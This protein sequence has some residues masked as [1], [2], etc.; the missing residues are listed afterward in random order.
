[1]L[2]NYK[3]H[4]TRVDSTV[5]SRGFKYVNET[6]NCRGTEVEDYFVLNLNPFSLAER[7]KWLLNYTASYGGRQYCCC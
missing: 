1:M 2:L 7:V 5:L 6:S 4:S 3:M